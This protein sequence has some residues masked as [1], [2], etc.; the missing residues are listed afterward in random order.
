MNLLK[1]KKIVIIGSGNIGTALVRGLVNSR[2]IPRSHIFIFDIDARKSNAVARAYRVNIMKG[3]SFIASAD[4]VILAVKPQHMED[5]ILRMREYLDENTLVISV[6]AGI[7]TAWLA[8]KIGKKPR[9][10]R[11]MPNTP[12]LIGRGVIAITRGSYAKASDESTACAL[13]QQCGS[14]VRV[15][16]RKMN[17]V[18]AVS[19]SG[20][21]YVF[22]LAEA[23]VKAGRLLGLSEK[24]SLLLTRETCAG[25]SE[26]M[27][28]ST[29][30]PRM[31]RQRVTS[32]GGTTESAICWLEK[33]KVHKHITDAVRKACCRAGKIQKK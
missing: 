14:V 9:I 18:T 28:Q 12:A 2:E 1:K 13:L 30:S 21:A 29:E 22:Y 19:G 15:P 6:A 17:A 33:N 23:M 31:L 25:A 32:P 5:C 7:T 20:P 3:Y 26:L 10:I 4:I 24:E 16:E 8:Q 11:S 27:K